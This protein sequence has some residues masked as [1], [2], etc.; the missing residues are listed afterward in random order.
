MAAAGRPQDLRL[1]RV[2]AKIRS[3][4]VTW[5]QDK[6]HDEDTSEEE[7]KVADSLGVEAQSGFRE[8]QRMNQGKVRAQRTSESF[9]C[10][11]PDRYEKENTDSVIQYVHTQRGTAQAIVS[12]FPRLETSTPPTRSLPNKSAMMDCPRTRVKPPAGDAESCCGKPNA[13]ADQWVM[14]GSRVYTQ[15]ISS[16]VTCSSDSSEGSCGDVEGK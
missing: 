5:I 7:S 14:T 15:Q 16:Q 6:D 8:L 9:A 4:D 10:G 11:T 1:G 13:A 3:R 2:A 12:E